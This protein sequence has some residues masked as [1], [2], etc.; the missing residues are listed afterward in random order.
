MHYE[1]G[2]VDSALIPAL[3]TELGPQEAN[4][5]FLS[6]HVLP[7]KCPQLLPCYTKAVHC[8]TAETYR[9]L[10]C[11]VQRLQTSQPAHL[12]FLYFFRN[13]ISSRGWAQWRSGSSMGLMR[14]VKLHRGAVET[15]SASQ[16]PPALCAG[17]PP[18]AFSQASSPHSRLQDISKQ[19][20][21]PCSFQSVQLI[22]KLR[23]R[24]GLPLV[25]H[26]PWWAALSSSD[27][28]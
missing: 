16:P 21:P 12:A 11:P 19:Q 15:T 22:C 18:F 1:K 8:R 24:A 5:L 9:F 4:T 6:H 2:E 25:S 28:C 14:S 20:E 13:L 10:V 27:S 17:T 26:H 23:E 7:R 3:P